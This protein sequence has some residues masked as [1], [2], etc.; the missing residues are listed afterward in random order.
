[1]IGAIALVLC[2]ALALY[3]DGLWE[4]R[5]TITAMAILGVTLASVLASAGRIRHEQ[6][7]AD[8]RSVAEAAQRV[9]LRPVPAGR[10]PG[11]A[12][13]SPTPPPRPRPAS[14]ATCTRSSPLRTASGSSSETSRARGSR[15]WRPRRWCW[16]PSARRRTTRPGSGAW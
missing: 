9:L 5:T 2:F 4:P 12:S 15:P 1:M 14:A 11:S 8:V 7:L 10:G 16:A 3:N 6:R 13:R